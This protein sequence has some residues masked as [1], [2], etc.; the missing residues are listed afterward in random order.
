VAEIII[1]NFYNS[2]H[3]NGESSVQTL[4]LCGAD[5][6]NDLRKLKKTFSTKNQEE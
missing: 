2:D 6:S 5:R 3:P 1:K 4:S